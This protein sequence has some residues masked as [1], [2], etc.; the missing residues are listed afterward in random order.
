MP[1]RIA[2]NRGATPQG[3]RR[4]GGAGR[5]GP[6]AVP[7]IAGEFIYLVNHYRS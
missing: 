6:V 2:H 5:D 3:V 7:G 4:G 1:P